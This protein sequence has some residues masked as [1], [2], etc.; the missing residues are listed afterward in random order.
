VPSLIVIVLCITACSQV[1]GAGEGPNVGF[2][3]SIFSYL[4][5][6]TFTDIYG[7]VKG[8]REGISCII[9]FTIV[10]TVWMIGYLVTENISPLLAGFAILWTVLIIVGN[11]VVMV[12]TR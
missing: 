1:L 9:F 7:L 4:S 2:A 5:L 3:I 10:N 12:K 6:I 11:S 8:C